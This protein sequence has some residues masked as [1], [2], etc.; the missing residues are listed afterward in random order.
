M[1]SLGLIAA[2]LAG[3]LAA[4]AS[5]RDAPVGTADV[6]T[7]DA[8]REAGDSG[9]LRVFTP[10]LR[11]DQEGTPVEPECDGSY[12]V[13]S[14]YSIYDPEGRLVIEVTN[15]SPLITSDEGPSVVGLPAGLYLI[16]LDCPAGE[17]RAFWMT[18]ESGRVSEVDA[19]RLGQV[20]IRSP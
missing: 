17:A 14:G 15:H 10:K 9:Y 5:P 12:A 8:R 4:C 19:T 7:A 6:A 11:V 13:P 2:A 3:S 1:K 20:E 18:V 16:V